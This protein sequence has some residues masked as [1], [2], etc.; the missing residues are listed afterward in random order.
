MRCQPSTIAN[1]YEMDDDTYA[2]N[3]RADPEV[4]ERATRGMDFF[5]PSFVTDKGIIGSI[6]GENVDI[7]GLLEFS[8]RKYGRLSIE[9]YGRL[10]DS[11][12]DTKQ[13]WKTFEDKAN[14]LHGFQTGLMEKPLTLATNEE[15]VVLHKKLREAMMAL[16]N[17]TGLDNPVSDV[18]GENAEQSVLPVS[19]PL[20]EAQEPPRQRRRLTAPVSRVEA[21]GETRVSAA[22][23]VRI[24]SSRGELQSG[25]GAGAVR[26]IHTGRRVRA[27][28]PRLPAPP[29]PLTDYSSIKELWDT[30]MEHKL[31]DLPTLKLLQQIRDRTPPYASAM[32]NGSQIKDCQGGKA[33]FYKQILRPLLRC[34]EQHCSCNIFRFRSKNKGVLCRAEKKLNGKALV[35][36]NNKLSVSAWYKGCKCILENE[37]NLI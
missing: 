37:N 1:H 28:G 9:D 7:K 24:T 14:A 4:F 34:Y 12:G 8:I 26:V 15:R 29:P 22:A 10:Y 16:N 31:Q 19:N 17:V 18:T 27:P 11:F 33:S 5:K 6:P 25:A 35:C 21:G 2:Q 32:R 13:A 3:I 23:Q 20:P 30:R 36:D